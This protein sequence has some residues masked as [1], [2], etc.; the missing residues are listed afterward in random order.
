MLNET[1]RRISELL[2]AVIGFVLTP[3]TVRAFARRGTETMLM[4]DLL[5]VAAG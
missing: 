5:A 2:A 1:M 4:R 3:N